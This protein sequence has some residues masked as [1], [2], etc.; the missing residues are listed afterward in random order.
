MVFDIK[1]DPKAKRP[2]LSEIGQQLLA[3]SQISPQTLYKKTFD[4][5]LAEQK[6]DEKL[7]LM[8]FNHYTK[9][10]QKNLMRL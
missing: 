1:A 5:F 10:R 8:H 3:N 7:A 9:M 4:D 6:D 2:P